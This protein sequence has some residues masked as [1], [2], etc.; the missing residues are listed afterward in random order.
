MRR[1]AFIPILASAALWLTCAGIAAAQSQAPADGRGARVSGVFGGAN[2]RSATDVSFAGAFGYRFDRVVGVEFEV[3][4]V[5][6]MAGRSRFPAIPLGA[7]GISSLPTIL[8]I[9]TSGRGVFFTANFR[10]EIP[11]GRRWLIPYFTGG[12]GVASVRERF[13]VN[14]LNRPVRFAASGRAPAR[15]PQIPAGQV[16]GGVLQTVSFPTIVRDSSNTTA[17]LALDLGGGVS[18]VILKGLSLDADLRFYRVF[19]DPEFN[20]VRFGTGASYRF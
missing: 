5:P 2:A 20:V 14:L 12:G 16:I 9:E 13:R 17:H 1:N 11:T 19:A 8:P 15:G 18:F 4:A 7:I 3:A 6:D 10:S